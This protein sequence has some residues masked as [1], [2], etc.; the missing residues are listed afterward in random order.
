MAV[1]HDEAVLVELHVRVID[2]PGRRLMHAS[3]GASGSSGPFAMLT[4][5]R[6]AGL[7]AGKPGVAAKR[8]QELIE[9]NAGF[10]AL[11][12]HFKIFGTS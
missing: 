10:I 9:V 6:R 12:F 3:E 8:F 11:Q 4:A 1:A 2:R 7:V 5:M